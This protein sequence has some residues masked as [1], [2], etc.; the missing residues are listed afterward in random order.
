MLVYTLLRLKV[1]RR[2]GI[3]YP[4]YATIYPH[5]VGVLNLSCIEAAVRATHLFR[6]T[7]ALQEVVR[8][9]GVD[10]DDVRDFLSECIWQN[11]V[12]HQEIHALNSEVLVFRTGLKFDAE[13]LPFV[14]LHW[15]CCWASRRFALVKV[16]VRVPSVGVAG[17]VWPGLLGV[18]SAS[19]GLGVR[20]LWGHWGFRVS[21]WGCLS[22]CGLG[23]GS[24]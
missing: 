23:G 11:G 16:C 9:G 15:C 14:R 13:G 24:F 2:F 21:V 7:L 5:S 6:S 10:A 20:G 4:R 17:R 1:H 12:I 19:V 3:T 22:P 18:R 8:A